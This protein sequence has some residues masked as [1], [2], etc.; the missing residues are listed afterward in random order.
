MSRKITTL[1]SLPDDGDSMCTE[2]GTCVGRHR[3]DGVPGSFV[4]LKAVSD[5]E[6]AA[7]LARHVGPGELV[8]WTPDELFDPY[9]EV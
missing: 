1:R 4:V 8:G 3:V 2:R 9:T 5:P 7:A 6:I